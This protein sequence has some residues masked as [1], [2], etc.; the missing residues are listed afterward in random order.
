MPPKVALIGCIVFVIWLLRV[1]RIDDSEASSA[2]WVPTIWFLIMASR[3]VGAWFITSSVSSDMEGSPYDRL[4][5]SI[6][7]ILSLRILIKRKIEWGQIFKD[8]SWL[9][10]LYFYLLCSV[11]WSEYPFVSLKRWIKIS[12]TI[13][14]AFV[15]LSEKQPLQALESIFRR[16]AYVLIPLSIVL[17]K[18]FPEYGRSYTSY[19]GIPMGTGVSTHKN[20][21]GALCAFS[22]FFLIWRLFC[23]WR[24]G[25]L[26]INRSQTI[27]DI[28]VISIALFLLFGGGG[29]SSATSIFIFIL[30][31]T[32]ILF[33]YRKKSLTRFIGTHLKK[34][35]VIFVLL[36]LLFGN[37]LLPVITSLLGR[38]DSLTGRAEIW[39]EVL[40]VA[41]NNPIIGVGYGGYWGVQQKGAWF[42]KMNVEQSHNGYLDVYLET[43][44]LG[45]LILSLFFLELCSKIRREFN[46]FFDWGVFGICFLF[47]V[48]LYNYTEAS[49]IS[50]SLYWTLT[51]FFTVVFTAPCLHTNGD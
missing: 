14:I 9:F 26:L 35:T 28:L 42:K 16:S 25:K 5:L 37:F 41:S 11:L 32:S 7:I 2:L 48:L 15:V 24:S 23:K 51:I 34:V 49:F 22:A 1:E 19:E 29:T 10:I 20:G 39:D 12:G 21:L 40:E 4:V 6:L 36:F 17:L 13:L 30:S 44:I 18:Y 8:N 50:P 27:G 43:G 3:P 47:T 45:I 33:L 46:Q 31:T 38:D